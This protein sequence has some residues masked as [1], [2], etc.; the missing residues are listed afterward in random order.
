MVNRFGCD[1][2]Q[3]ID[4]F[5]GYA[6][7]GECSVGNGSNPQDVAVVS[8]TRVYVSRYESNWLL[9]INPQTCAR[10]DSISLAAFADAD[11]TVEMHRMLLRGS[12]LYVELQRLDRSSFPM[13]R[14]LDPTSR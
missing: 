5:H 7:V 13:F 12:R 3:L 2:I 9:E 4:P 1:S 11:G 8:P 14:W 10:T 6:T